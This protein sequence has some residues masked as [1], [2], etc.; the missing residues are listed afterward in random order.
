MKQSV[1]LVSRIVY[2]RDGGAIDIK[3]DLYATK[4]L[5][6]QAVKREL[7]KHQLDTNDLDMQ[8]DHFDIN[9]SDYLLTPRISYIFSEKKIISH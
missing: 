1:W 5:A 2:A 4:A 8:K 7:Q 6:Y 3:D 9:D